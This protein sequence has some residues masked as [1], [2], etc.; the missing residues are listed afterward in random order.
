MLKMALASQGTEAAVSLHAETEM[1]R[2][3][4]PPLGC[5]PG[6]GYSRGGEGG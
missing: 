2:R 6:L 5:A 4:F 1:G 3:L